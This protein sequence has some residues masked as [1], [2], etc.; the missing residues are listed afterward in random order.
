MI[1]QVRVVSI[2]LDDTLWAI[3]PAIERAEILLQQWLAREVP[4]V[5][6]LLAPEAMREVRL[7][8]LRRHP[9][10]H[11]DLMWIRR[12][13]IEAAFERAGADTARVQEAF[14]VFNEGR[15]SVIPF[16][17]AMPALS[18]LVQ[19]YPVIAISNGFADIARIGIAPYLKLY[20]TSRDVGVAKPDP[21]IFHYA[22]RM[23]GA[24][25]A[26]VLHVGDDAALD[27]LGARCAGL[28]AAWINRREDAWPHED[29]G[30]HEFTDMQSFATWL[31]DK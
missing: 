5:A 25:P 23:V 19:R 27:V 29:V 17:D 28:H 12:R 3:G 21:A 6:P 24:K 2:D 18:R 13:A 10:M 8:M 22:C 30:H 11:H 9:H 4:E 20:V 26:E 16:P 1:K 14:D 15:Q 7:E 31:L